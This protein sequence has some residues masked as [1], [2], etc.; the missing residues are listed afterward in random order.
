MF[1]CQRYRGKPG[2]RQPG[3]QPYRIQVAA[4]VSA[5]MEFHAHLSTK[6]VVGLLGGTVDEEQRLIQ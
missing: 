4:S 6:E 2:S 3:T 1:K 5:T